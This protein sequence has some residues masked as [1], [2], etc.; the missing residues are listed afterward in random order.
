[1]EPITRQE[2]LM[3]GQYVEPITRTE[4]ILAGEDIEPVTRYEYFLKKY[5]GGGGGDIDV[6]Q[7]SVT[8]NGDYTAPEGKAYSPVHVAVPESVLTT[9]NI[10]ANGTYN[11]SS[12]N[13]DGYSSV[14]VDVPLPENAYLLKTYEDVPA[15]IATFNDGSDLPVKELVVNIDPI[16]SGSGDP[17]PSN[18]R[19][20]SGRTE[21]NITRTGKNLLDIDNTERTISSQTT[22]KNNMRV[23]K[24]TY[25]FSVHVK[26]NSNVNGF[27]N[28]VY[29]SGMDYLRLTATAN[30]EGDYSGTVTFTEEKLLTVMCNG[31]SAGYSYV[32]S[33]IMLESG[34][35]STTYAPYNG[36]TYTIQLGSTYYGAELD[37]TTGLMTVKN[38]KTTINDLSWNY[39]DSWAYPPVFRS[40]NISDRKIS[41]FVIC[42]AY[43]KVDD[44]S[45][46]S[47]IT[48]EN[49]IIGGV[50]SANN[51]QIRDDD[52]SSV[53]AFK[54]AMGSTKI[55]YEL[56][57]PIEVQLTPTQV[58][59][60]LGK[61]NLYADSGDVV[62]LDYLAKE[63]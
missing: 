6:V 33:N 11:A 41:G 38:V 1:M 47:A 13:A 14:T 24:G 16:Q 42:E 27:V 10:T 22:I 51:L 35:E 3:D 60:I 12:D 54:A 34:D 62:K 52:Y 49:G 15:S 17:S 31:A 20:I 23:P 7:L 40:G 53:S 61:N 59:T 8:E 58:N 32:V 46:W 19:T 9:K 2:K 21:S 57:T 56:A 44:A 63:V 37:V 18:I 26:N 43:K 39:V 36:H 5:R 55:V 25:T 48:S 29:G 28:L 50:T 30:S 45:S 4:K